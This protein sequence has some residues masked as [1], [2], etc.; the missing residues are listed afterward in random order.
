MTAKRAYDL[1]GGP[2]V[3]LKLF[4][5]HREGFQDMPSVLKNDYLLTRFREGLN[6]SFYEMRTRMFCMPN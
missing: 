6:K 5:P 1:V 2:L 3:H 4:A